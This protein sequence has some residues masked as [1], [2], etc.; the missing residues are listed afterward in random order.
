MTLPLICCKVGT[1]AQFSFHSFL[2]KCMS[3]QIFT[4]LFTVFKQKLIILYIN[5]N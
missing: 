4:V 3:A 1:G 2:T 5:Y